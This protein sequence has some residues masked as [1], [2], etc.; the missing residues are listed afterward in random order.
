MYLLIII[1]ILVRNVFMFRL[2]FIFVLYLSQTSFASYNDP[3]SSLQETGVAHSEDA[4]KV[5][6][7]PYG[8]NLMWV[9]KS[10]TE[11]NTYIFPEKEADGYFLVTQEWAKSNPDSQYLYLWYDSEFVSLNQVGN[12]KARLENKGVDTH[13]SD[14]LI[15]Q[16]KACKIILQDLRKIPLVGE[17]QQVFSEKIDIYFR[18]DLLRV[19]L[20]DHLI[21]DKGERG[22]IVYSDFNV[23]WLSYDKLFEDQ[24]YKKYTGYTG[25]RYTMKD[26]DE[27][28]LVLAVNNRDDFLRLYPY[29][30]GFY[31]LN[32]AKKTMV[33]AC[34][35]ALIDINILRAVKSIQDDNYLQDRNDKQC[36]YNSYSNVAKLSRYYELR[37][38]IIDDVHGNPASTEDRLEAHNDCTSLFE[39]SRACQAKFQLKNFETDIFGQTF[40][41]LYEKGSSLAFLLPTRQVEKPISSFY[42]NLSQ[43]DK[44]RRSKDNERLRNIGLISD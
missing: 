42:T 19:I 2:F 3:T 37:A 43:N 6:I 31:I 26:L 23:A 39:I 7:K 41:K 4:E 38:E 36:V 33:K 5:T 35:L 29:E 18:V 40:E 13:E 14:S 32:A 20:A 28:G 34:R 24:P 16:H 1:F 11:E 15:K 27:I 9:N 25:Y 12:T 10:L 21:K 30:N 22:Y 8:I 44:K 17:Y